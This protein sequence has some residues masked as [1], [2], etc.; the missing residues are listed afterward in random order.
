MANDSDEDDIPVLR[1][2]VRPGTRTANAPPEPHGP[3]TEAVGRTPRGESDTVHATA[4]SNTE[5]EA[6]A[7]RVVE[8]Q[9]AKI[10]AAVAQA[11]RQAL[12]LRARDRDSAS[13]DGSE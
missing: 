7:E 12:E 11:I 2:L 9:T 5:I 3:T 6:I 8:R 10:N 4:L 13:D 1:D